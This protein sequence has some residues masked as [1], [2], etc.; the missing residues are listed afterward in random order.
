[1]LA[2]ACCGLLLWACGCT[3]QSK[4]LRTR[5]DKT[6]YG[7]DDRFEEADVTSDDM[8]RNGGATVALV[9]L[10][11]LR[12]DSR[13]DSYRNNYPAYT[14]D[15]AR[16]GLCPGERYGGQSAIAYCSG[17]LIGPDLVATAGHCLAGDTTADM[18]R[19]GTCDSLG[20]LV[21]DFTD[22]SGGTFPA[23][24]VYR[25]KEVSGP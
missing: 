10:T 14:L 6:L 11:D 9:E 19:K 2:R 18:C 22:E 23:E 8:R 13:T 1:M 21:F 16:G 15:Y 24:N 5:T 17:T 20:Y 12:Y 4:G 7:T 3:A 25:C